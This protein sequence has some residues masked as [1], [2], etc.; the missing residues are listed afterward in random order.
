MTGN[1]PTV[2]SKAEA[3]AKRV[4]EPRSA[5]GRSAASVAWDA[6]SIGRHLVGQAR[7]APSLLSS[8]GDIDG[9]GSTRRYDRDFFLR[10]LKEQLLPFWQRHSVDAEYGGFV[11]HLDRAGR[12]YEESKWSPMQGRMVYAFSLAYE[13]TGD[14]QYRAL[15]DHGVEYLI[16]CCWDR[17]MGGWYRCT[18]RD[19]VVL[20]ARKFSF[21]QAFACLGLVEH[22]AATGDEESLEYAEETFEILER[23]AWDRQHLGYAEACHRN[24]DVFSPRRTACIQL[25]AHIT[26]LALLEASGHERY[27]SRLDQLAELITVHMRDRDRRCLLETFN[28]DWSYSPLATRDRVKVGHNLKAAWLLL[29]TY[30]LTNEERYRLAAL[31]LLTWCLRH[32]W[33]RDRGGFYQHVFRNGLLASS[34]K[35]WWPEC[36]G[37]LALLLLDQVEESTD[38]MNLWARV[39]DFIL[40]SFW[41][42]EHGEWYTS[43]RADGTVLDPTKGG[44]AKAAYHTVQACAY[45]AR[46]LDGELVGGRLR[47]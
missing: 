3:A 8:A 42:S 35:L 10:H 39:A 43:C 9:G 19:G 38:H 41:D 37:L 16:R 27:R 17:R 44:E 7:Q 47:G 31:E 24:W 21:D 33:D 2:R 29:R 12:W 32:G 6:Y 20:D 28:A 14:E 4:A 46:Y 40:A 34:E 22:H 1:Q 30:L 18:Y 36:E 45:A 11:T 23:S 15:A 25:D 13:V 26:V 5:A